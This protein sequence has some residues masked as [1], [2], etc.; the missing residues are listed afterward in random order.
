MSGT[1]KTFSELPPTENDYIIA[2][3]SSLSRVKGC[4]LVINEPKSD[5][6]Y[7]MRPG[8]NIYT[9]LKVKVRW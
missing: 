6:V 7:F 5:T 9:V 8:M 3:L 1:K 4:H 2:L